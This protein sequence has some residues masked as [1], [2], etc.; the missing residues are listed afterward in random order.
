MLRQLFIGYISGV[1]PLNSIKWGRDNYR[2]I[3]SLI[4]NIFS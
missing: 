2:G 4:I 3:N 1:L